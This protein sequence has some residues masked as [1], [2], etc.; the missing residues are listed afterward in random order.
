VRPAVVLA[1]ALVLAGC[2]GGARGHGTATL[3]VTRDRGAHVLFA[4][5]VPAGL[6]GI[7]TVERR[8]KVT[9]RYGGRYVQSIDGVSGSLAGQHDW[10][11]FVDGVEG[12][13]SAAEV[14]VRPG[15][16]LWWDFRHWTPATM[17]VPAVVGAYPEP[18][19][20]HGSTSVSAG[21]RGV[22][23]AIA[24]EVHGVVAAAKPTR[25]Q[26]LI[27][28]SVPPRA[29]R[30]RPFRSGWTLELG[31]TIAARLAR[32]PTALRFRF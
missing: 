20:H 22:A 32:D 5:R 3:W 30:I 13:R 15:A 11:Y 1:L 18:F 17:E 29:A 31:S 19:L 25:N 7:Q 27:G 21:D 26:I 2:G 8:L 28:G 14:T 12:G 6:N 23:R 4:G 10:F 24:R 16:V 9:T